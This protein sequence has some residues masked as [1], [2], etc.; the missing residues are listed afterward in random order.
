MTWNVPVPPQ[1]PIKVYDW[2][3]RS[4]GETPHL[5]SPSIGCTQPLYW[6]IL[7]VL[8]LL[9]AFWGF[10][11]PIPFN[12]ILWVLAAA[13]FT[14]LVVLLVRTLRWSPSMKPL[15]VRRLVACQKCG[16]EA[17]GPFQPG[18]YV[19]KPIGSCPRC[20]GSLYVKALYGIEASE[21]LKRQQPMDA[22]N[23]KE[24]PSQSSQVCNNS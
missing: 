14:A 16:V 22:S 21:P 17:E 4:S 2:H 1:S 12:L 7:L 5:T 18:D 13:S 6:A 15:E 9:L 20:G 10:L 19:F 11:F 24:S 3:V 8:G 23:L